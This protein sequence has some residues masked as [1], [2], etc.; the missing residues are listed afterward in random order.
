LER[1]E[2]VKAESVS[3]CQ[4]LDEVLGSRKKLSDQGTDLVEEVEEE[5]QKLRR[6]RRCSRD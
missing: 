3:L 1:A 5:L 4:T 2:R 6:L